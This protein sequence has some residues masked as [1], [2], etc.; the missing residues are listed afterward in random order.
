MAPACDCQAC[1]VSLGSSRV[2]LPFGSECPIGDAFSW[3]RPMEQVW[4][5]VAFFFREVVIE[6]WSLQASVRWLRARGQVYP[7]RKR[8]AMMVAVDDF[9]SPAPVHHDE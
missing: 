9:T 4:Q 2:R 3:R 6:R 1:P 8:E 7:P 5:E